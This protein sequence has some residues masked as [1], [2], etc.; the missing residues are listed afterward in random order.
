MEIPT[1]GDK[2][3]ILIEPYTRPFFLDVSS[4]KKDTFEAF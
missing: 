4:D 1:E 2:H 3:E